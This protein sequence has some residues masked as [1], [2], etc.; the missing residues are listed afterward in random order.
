VLERKH[1]IAEKNITMVL[2]YPI[3]VPSESD[4]QAP[5]IPVAVFDVAHA[6]SIQIRITH[7]IIL[8]P[9]TSSPPTTL[10]FPAKASIE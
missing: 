10:A 6:D 5:L 1:S 4:V 8:P 9:E 3:I 7:P 2:E